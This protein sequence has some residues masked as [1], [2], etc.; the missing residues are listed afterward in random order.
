M[1]K[2]TLEADAA[3]RVHLPDD[4]ICK[5]DICTT[6]YG[7]SFS[8]DDA[9]NFCNKAILCTTNEQTHHINRQILDR[10]QGKTSLQR[11]INVKQA[12]I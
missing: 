4:I 2:G 3:N 12:L 1:G 5:N 10:L 8:P 11:N 6:I 9:D 7:A